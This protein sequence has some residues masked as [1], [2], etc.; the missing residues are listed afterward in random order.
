MDAG[1]IVTGP[2]L[3]WLA[4]NRRSE[5]VIPLDRLG[6]FIDYDRLAAVLARQPVTIQ[7]DG[8]Q[9]GVVTRS[10]SRVYDTGNLPTGVGGL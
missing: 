4:M 9:L 1:G 2:T 5:A 6:G 8:Q 7:V 3:A 10:A